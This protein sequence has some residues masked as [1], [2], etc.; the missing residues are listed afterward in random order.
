VA[1]QNPHSQVVTLDLPVADYAQAVAMSAVEVTDEYLFQGIG[2][3][4]CIPPTR[5]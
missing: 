2:R 3:G 5:P 4:E 1:S